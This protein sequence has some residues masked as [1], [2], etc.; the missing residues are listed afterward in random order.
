MSKGGLWWDWFA[1]YPVWLE[2]GS[3]AFWKR[4]RR[5]RLIEKDFYGW[6]EYTAYRA[7]V[8]QGGLPDSHS[9]LI[10]MA[11]C[12]TGCFLFS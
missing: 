10:L 12:G 8:T 9:E 7:A 2:D 6:H 3:M 5:A 4:V 11:L 1:W